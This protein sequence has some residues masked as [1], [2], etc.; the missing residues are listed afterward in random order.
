MRVFKIV[1]LS[2]QKNRIHPNNTVFSKVPKETMSCWISQISYSVYLCSLVLGSLCRKRGIKTSKKFE[3][4]ACNS[5]FLGQN[6]FTVCSFFILNENTYFPSMPFQ[7][8]KKKKKQSGDFMVKYFKR[9]L[10][11]GQEN[12]FKLC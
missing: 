7:F 1:T 9:T 5:S 12:T 10:N 4:G 2:S 6:I 11:T 8:W 3:L